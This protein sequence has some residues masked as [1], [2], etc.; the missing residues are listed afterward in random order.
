[1]AWRM[2]FERKHGFV[3]NGKS[4][5]WWDV[6]S[7]VPQVSVLGPILFLIYINDIDEGLACNISKF[8]D[9]TKITSKVTTPT[10]KNAT[11]IQLRYFS[12]LVKKV[13]NEI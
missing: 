5:N 11:T 10:E 6:I 4:S 7:S 3:I 2:A 13:A 12:Q 1:M 8:A 9:H